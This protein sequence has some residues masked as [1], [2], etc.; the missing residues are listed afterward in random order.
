MPW[1]HHPGRP[2]FVDHCHIGLALLE[3]SHPAANRWLQ[4]LA[5][6]SHRCMWWQVVLVLCMDTAAAATL[7]VP[8]CWLKPASEFRCLQVLSV[9]RCCD[10]EVGSSDE[11]EAVPMIGRRPIPKFQLADYMQSPTANFKAGPS[12]PVRAEAPANSVSSAPGPS[13]LDLDS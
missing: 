2:A 8:N 12:Q 9:G 4:C 11:N 7:C 5:A 3:S 13:G 10:M 6:S 1:F